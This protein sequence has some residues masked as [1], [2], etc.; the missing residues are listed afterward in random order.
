[1]DLSGFEPEASAFLFLFPVT[2]IPKKSLLL[3]GMQGQRSTTE[4]Q[5]HKKLK[6]IILL[7]NSF[8]VFGMLKIFRFSSFYGCASAKN[9]C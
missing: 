1:M 6:N 5:A 7:E 4:L 3:W 2:G 9:Y 8:T